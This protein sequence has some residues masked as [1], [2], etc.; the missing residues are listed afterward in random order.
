MNLTLKQ[1][2]L[3]IVL[4][5][6]IGLTTISG[7]V[8]FELNNVFNQANYGNAN[9]VG[10]IL[11]LAD[12]R[13]EFNRTR[14]LVELHASENDQ[15]KLLNIEKEIKKS[16]YALSDLLTKY[17]T[18]GCIGVSCVSDDKDQRYLN[19]LKSMLQ[20]L[21]T[22]IDTFLVSSKNKNKN[23][24]DEAILDDQLKMQFDQCNTL[25]Q[26]M[27]L[28][29][30]KL[31][32]DSANDAQASKNQALIKGS[33]ISIT[34]LVIVTFICLFL[35]R[36]VLRN[37]GG[38]PQEVTDVVKRVATGD[39]RLSHILD[40]APENSLLDNIKKLVQ[41]L[42][43]LAVQTDLIGKG[44][45]S[46]EARVLSDHDRLSL[47]INNMTSLL[48]AA[49]LDNDA[50]N[51]L[52][53]GSSQIATALTGDYSIQELSDLSITILGRYLNAGRA[54]MY[55]Y[56]DDDA[57]LDL[58]GSYMYTEREHLGV[59]C[60]LGEGAIGQVAR[61]RKPIILTTISHDTA[62]ITTGTTSNKPL[63]TYTYPL[64]RDEALL[65]VIELASFVKFEPI[66]LEFVSNAC[67]V[68]A[69]FL[70]IAEQRDSIRELLSKATAAE[71]DARQQSERLQEANAQM[72]EQQQQLQQQSEELRQANAQMEEQ[73]LVLEQNN[74]A[75]K[76]SQLELDLKAKDLENSGRYKSEF[77]ANM[78]HELRTPLNAI[79]LLSKLMATNSDHSLSPEDVKRAEVILRSGKDLLALIN[80]VL[81][82]S[83]IEAG[84]MD[85]AYSEITTTAFT[86][87]LQDLFGAQA[88]EKNLQFI[89]DDQLK[90]DFVSDHDKLAQIMRNLLSNAF[91]FTKKGSVTLR[92]TKHL[93]HRLPICL[94]VIDTGVG[95]PKEKQEVIFEAFRQ[96]DGSTSREFGGTG[97]GLTISRSIATLLGGTIDIQSV[98][99]QGSTFSLYLPEKPAGWVAKVNHHTTSTPLPGSILPPIT[100]DRF[101]INPGDKLI[102]LIDDDPIFRMALL[103][104]NRRLGYKTLLAEN[105]TQGIA[106]A[107][108]YQPSGILLDL[109]LPDIDGALVLE[110][111]KSSQDLASIPIYIVSAR[112]HSAAKDLTHSIGYLQKPANESQL[113]EAEATL[114]SFVRQPNAHAILTITSGGVTAEEIKTLLANQPAHD[115]KMFR[116]VRAEEDISAALN[117]G[118]WSIAI[119]DL[120]G[121]SVQRAI[122][123]AQATKE[124]NTHTA[125]IF[126]STIE[127]NETDEASLHRYSDC[128]IIK[129]P[130][131][132]SRLLLNIERFLNQIKHVPAIKQSAN[133]P[134]TQRKELAGQSIL[135]VDDD[136]RNLFA[137]TAALEQHGAKVLCAI[138]GKLALAM[139]DKEGVDLI[140]MDIMMPEMDGYEVIAAV[141]ANAQLSEIPIIA[142]TAKAMPQDKQK[143]LDVGANDYLSK[144]VDFD[145]LIHLSKKWISSKGQH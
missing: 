70:Y 56:K 133:R 5:V 92:I 83:K 71:Q 109:G 88:E 33:L 45:F 61:E 108:T 29:N 120:T 40:S 75:L 131:S 25:I 122:E 99:N 37:L 62:P 64:M 74:Q 2:M 139:L 102:L 48:R 78:S 137:V 47:S 42:A 105:G 113:I 22:D 51:W 140:L 84:H 72:E 59:R 130:Q 111:I 129:T 135:V 39:L 55:I 44:D 68:I 43:D 53:D 141:R 117:E 125:L 87:Y 89:I 91:K 52:K 34:L 98:E 116:E 8:L 128:I 119:I 63:F 90:S 124:R 6:G 14:T 3:L 69:S 41:N 11:I 73:Q 107:H 114:L 28:Y 18:N 27:L 126:M 106:M 86:S 97:L 121:I 132:E 19:S 12:T 76:Q 7:F 100:D 79:I 85:I 94:S 9:T 123:I 96:A 32:N 60:K 65:G 127:L 35:A 118:I 50:R 26:D 138:S 110:K 49:K 104:I 31:G 143:I 145:D 17:E 13:E 38:D 54:V 82:L 21:S 46:K 15:Q 4:V 36:A 103:E 30:V 66:H 95:I 142:L 1:K 101:H 136:P 24:N 93:G 80:D 23:K 134:E 67:G 10:S 16:R 115:Q 77:L 20:D 57:A 58:M 81:D 112:D 144:P